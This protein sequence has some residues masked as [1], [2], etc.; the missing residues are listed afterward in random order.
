RAQLAEL[1]DLHGAAALLAWDQ[2]T[3]M[4]PGGADAR[5]DQLATL[6][7]LW[8]ARLVDPALARLLDALEPWAAGIDP[9]GDDARLIR[10]ARRDHEKA[11]RVPEALAVGMAREGARGYAAW[12]AA[13]ETGDFGRFRDPLARQ[14]ELRREYA[15]CFPE[16]AHP[17][18]V[19]LD[20]FEPG[21]TTAEVRPL[22]EALVT[23][24]KPLVADAADADDAEP[25]NG[26]FAGDF[27][28]D[29]QRA[30]LESIL[31]E[32]GFDRRHWRL[33]AS[34]HPFAQSPG[35]G[36]IRITSR[37]RSDDLAFSLYS[38]LHE[39][40]H[41]LYDANLG[42]E[43]RRTPLHECA[44]L[45]IHESQSRTWE[46]L[47][48]R[49]RPFC[50]WL[51]PHLQRLLPGFDGLS[52]DALYRGVNAVQRTLIRTE[53]DETTYNLHVALRMDLELALLEARL[54]VDDLPAA[55]ATGMRDLLGLEVPDDARGVLQDVHWAQGS[56]G[57]FPTYTL[58]NL[59]AA[60]LWQQVREDLPDLDERIG[61]GEFRPL[62]DWLREHVHRHGRKYTQR[63]LLR[64]A[65]RQELS[66]EPF[67]EYLR[68]KLVDTGAL[69]SA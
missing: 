35:H 42:P 14:V 69:A 53:A 31:G 39:F 11:V 28:V 33:D 4:P 48:G 62:R 25:M 13:R 22:F 41:G 15:A 16:A 46:N 67:L 1:M 60:Q 68:A 51:L 65:T 5:A 30:A 12:I 21:M 50:G 58:G 27:A 56:F 17:Y 18:D 20:D 29:A 2:N 34:P 37:Y 66:V 54:E 63:E 59:M 57:Y 23:A 52:A 7:R 10:V 45:G 61:A 32:L 40:G 47:V 19:L 9:D 26:V 44:S 6:E 24:L 43:L 3:Y 55:W 38:G 49:S 8:H 64:R 36:D